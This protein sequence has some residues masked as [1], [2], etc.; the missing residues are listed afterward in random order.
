[1]INYQKK[2][3]K[4]KNK[5]LELKN[6][7]AGELDG[8]TLT[9]LYDDNNKFGNPI[10]KQ[11]NSYPEFKSLVHTQKISDLINVI[12]KY[13]NN[14]RNIPNLPFELNPFQLLT[15]DNIKLFTIDKINSNNE[16]IFKELTKTNEFIQI[17]GRYFFKLVGLAQSN[18][19]VSFKPK[20]LSK[21]EISHN[22]LT[23][24]HKLILENG[25]R[26][27]G[28]LIN[29]ILDGRGKYISK[30]GD[31]YEGDF[32][33]N[34]RNGKGKYISE[35]GYIYEGEFVNNKRQGKGI[36]IK[37][38]RSKYE[39]DFVNNKYE[40]KGKYMK[41]DGY[42]YEGDFVNGIR[43]G[44]GIEFKSN[45]DRYEGN[46]VNDQRNGIGIE[47]LSNGDRYEGNFVNGK[48]D[49]K[50]IE[51]LSNGYK[52]ESYWENGKRKNKE[53]NKEISDKKKKVAE[54]WEIK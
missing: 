16:V 10:F 2:Y 18:T 37:S 12:I 27:E 17:K 5:Y 20:P 51:T 46:F 54:W 28:N 21:S 45:G 26:Y 50:S 9:Y 49:G 53:D 32:V 15:K 41:N 1:M 44:K 47:T 40:G 25:D 34:K 30:N 38:N 19:T 43:Q 6:Q 3:L 29:N 11:I 23:G 8:I 52:Y 4:Y 35:D 33:N 48:R 13:I 22:L 42:T 7:L 36:E 24:Y 31:R 39:G 14:N